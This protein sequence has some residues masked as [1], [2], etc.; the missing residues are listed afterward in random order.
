MSRNCLDRRGPSRPLSVCVSALLCASIFLPA[1]PLSAQDPQDVAEAARQEKARKAAQQKKEAH[2]YTNDDLKQSQIL[3]EEDR[4]RVEARKNDPGNPVNRPVMPSFEVE[5]SPAPQSLGEIARRYRREKAQRDAEEAAKSLSPSLFPMDMNLGQPAFAVPLQ[6]VAPLV[7]PKSLPWK[8]SKPVMRVSPSTSSKRDPFSRQ[9]VFPSMGNTRPDLSPKL[10]APSKPVAPL[11][12]VAPHAPSAHDTHPAVA[13]NLVLPEAPVPTQSSAAPKP[14]RPSLAPQSSIVAPALPKSRTAPLPAP[15][16]IPP[17]ARGAV[18]SLAPQTKPVAPYALPPNVIVAPYGP[19]SRTAPA[20]TP[21][22]V[23]PSQPTSVPPSLAPLAKPVAPSFTPHAAAVIPDVKNSES[24]G[25]LLVQPGDSLWAL[26]RRRLGRGSR[27]SEF[28]SSNP[29]I[30]D[31]NHIQAG[32]VLVVPSTD[33]RSRV[34]PPKS[35]VV[36]SGDSLWKL[37]ASH[38]G[39]GSAWTCIARANPQLQNVNLLHLG[40]TL[41]IPSSCAR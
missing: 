1:S 18:P 15:N 30:V 25:T 7:P 3:T 2:V 32:T 9:L 33:L 28:L 12:N 31:P 23:A 34:Q 20:P 38:L 35:L 27:W 10:A 24:N 14:R 26:A 11:V 6:P 8:S 41:T 40:Q 4:A 22:F 19:K 5:N 39:N 29:A 13:P 16:L 36:R 21:K 17:A 37:A